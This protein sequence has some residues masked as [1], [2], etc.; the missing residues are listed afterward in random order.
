MCPGAQANE[1]GTPTEDKTV[2]SRKAEKDEYSTVV[3]ASRE[4]EKQFEAARGIEAISSKTMNEQQSASMPEALEY[5]TGALMQQTNRGAGSPIM[6]GLVGPQNLIV[7][8]HLRFNSSIYRTGPNHYLATF[9]H[10]ALERIE[11]VRGPSS[12]LFGDGA[13]GGVVHL[14]TQS[15]SYGSD[16]P[17]Y[18][19]RENLGFASAD[20]SVVATGDILWAGEDAGLLFGGSFRDYGTLRAGGGHEVPMSNYSNENWRLK[21]LRRF[22]DSWK[23]SLAHFGGRVRDAGRSDELGLGQ[24]RTYDNDDLF[25]YAR[26]EYR[27]LDALKKVRFSLMHHYINDGMKRY[28]CNRGTEG[29]VVD[30]EAC[31]NRQLGTLNSQSFFTDNVHVAGSETAA[32]FNLLQGRFR[33]VLGAEGYF[34]WVGSSGERV[35]Q[36]GGSER[37]KLERG[38]FSDGSTYQTLGAYGHGRALIWRAARSGHELHLSGGGRGSRFA[39]FAPEVPGAAPDG[40]QAE[41]VRYVFQGFVGSLGVQLLKPRT[42]NLYLNYLQG[43]RAPNL[44]ETTVVGDTGSKFEV[45]NP[46]LSPESSTT[47]ELGARMAWPK[48]QVDVVGYISR[49]DD[50]IDEAQ[51]SYMPIDGG[52]ETLD[53]VKRVNTAS[54]EYHGVEAVTVAELGRIQ[55]RNNVVW[56]VGE[57]RD[58]AGDEYPARRV[59]PL[60]GSISMRHDSPDKKWYV[61]SGLR[62]ALAQNKLHPSDT[63]DHRICET[64]PYSGQLQAPCDGTPAFQVY[65]LWGGYKTAYALEVD[66][67]IR[68]IFDTQYRTH[69]SGYDAAGVDFRFTLRYRH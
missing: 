20:N 5:A 7:V 67:A 49:L 47:V 34:E 26:V 36:P 23:M 14:V 65:D 59:P 63:K 37:E 39:A 25:S 62:W 4:Q 22:G 61:G 18:L 68:N 45:A 17:G 16:T 38:N 50:A 51:I 52:G 31:A 3:T 19:F 56:T 48:V 58:S 46:D 6:R 15:P 41:D 54:A 10:E 8:D 24:V 40:V 13:M 69:G 60:F 9:D 30:S 33:L 35:D 64:A 66:T 32:S 43:F 42:Y 27:G 44:H 1:L 12:V 57:Y 29:L 2:G 28:D 21:F 53:A 55:L 11:I